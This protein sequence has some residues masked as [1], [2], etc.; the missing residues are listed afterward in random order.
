MGYTRKKLSVHI[1]EDISTNNQYFG[2]PKLS[3]TKLSN[4]NNMDVKEN[5]KKMK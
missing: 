4:V 2:R 5:V 1:F 3:P